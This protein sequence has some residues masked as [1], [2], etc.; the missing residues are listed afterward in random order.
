MFRIVNSYK[1]ITELVSWF[2]D[3][4]RRQ[5][6]LD[7]ETTGKEVYVPDFKVRTIQFGHP[8]EAWFMSFEPWKGV[9]Q[10]LIDA[11]KP[12]FLVHSTQYEIEAL[13]TQNV[14]LPW[15]KVADTLIAMRLA[16]PHRPS[17]LKPAATR[18]VSASAANS[19]QALHDGMRK[20]KWTWAT[21]PLDYPPYQFYAAMDVILTSRLA[22]TAICQTGFNSPVYG[23]EMDYRALCC[24]MERRGLRFD[25]GACQE[26]R[27]RFSEEIVDI[28]EG[29]KEK[30]G[31][32]LT[33]N[34][35]L[36]RWL[37]EN[38]APMT[39]GT[40]GGGISVALDALE[41]ARENLSPGQV[42]VAEVIDATLRIRK[43]TGLCSRYLT[44][45]LDGSEN[46]I[47]HPEINT[48]EARTGRS[49][50]R[51]RMPLQ[52]LPRGDDE[53]SKVVRR[54]V[55]PNNPG[56]LLI[57]CDYDQIE[58]R[59][60]AIL[61]GD[62]ALI[63]AFRVA[64]ETGLDFF[65]SASRAIYNE[66]DF[67]KSDPRRTPVKNLFYASSFGASVAKMARMSGIA[68]DEMQII[69]NKVFSKFPD[70]KKIMKICEN[71]ARNNDWWITTPAGRR[72]WVDPS[73]P[74]VALNCKV[75][76]WAGD[77][78]K[79]GML[80]I[81]NAGLAEHLVLP[82]HDEALL[83]LQEDLIDEARPVIR[84]CMQYLDMSVPLL[85]E[86]SMGCINWALAK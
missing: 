74:Y 72:L 64:D 86:P 49:S 24:D 82:I 18:H 47:I 21:V 11:H 46:G 67:M 26:A 56:E 19:Q 22:E 53:D 23:M 17:G 79:Q 81:A 31:I 52:T 66:S 65:T 5:L 84:D 1:D 12:D 35:A 59:V 34:G 48:C 39:K 37:V 73:K 70:A 77:L 76:G 13:R 8:T 58:L 54:S 3:N 38:N 2:E 43:L 42:E 71:E 7:I 33:S 45:I 36:G 85:A 4:Q 29:A 80:N 75:Q 16:E 83:S 40:D 15:N 20:N 10:H 14:T 25:V 60:I 50:I 55:I 9:I 69:Y 41:E 68:T 51:G 78:F 28:A 61:S 44:K 62:K 57:S 63:E 27:D 30:Y 6:A 32:S